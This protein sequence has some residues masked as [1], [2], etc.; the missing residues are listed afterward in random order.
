[1]SIAWH[2]PDLEHEYDRV[3]VHGV[4]LTQFPPEVALR[5]Y[6]KQEWIDWLSYE[7]NPTHWESKDGKLVT[8]SRLIRTFQGVPGDR[9]FHAARKYLTLPNGQVKNFLVACRTFW[10]GKSKVKVLVKGSRSVMHGG[11][12]HFYYAAH[13]LFVCKDIEIHFVDPNEK[14]DEFSYKTESQSVKLVWSSA[15]YHG[16]GEGFDVLIDDAWEPVSGV[17]P[18]QPCSEYYSLKG[19]QEES[20]A[21]YIPFLH[22]RETRFFSHTPVDSKTPCG[23]CVCREISL[24]AS[25]FD[26]YEFLRHACT[27]LD[28]N[29]GCLRTSFDHDLKAKGDLLRALMT[30]TTVSI[31]KPVEVRAVMSLV[32]CTR[33]DFLEGNLVQVSE[34]APRDHER[35]LHNEPFVVTR[36]TCREVYPWL[37]GKEVIFCGVNPSVLGTTRTVTLTQGH[38]GGAMHHIAFCANIQSAMM[39]SAATMY[40]PGKV[41]DILRHLP[42]WR[43]TGRSVKGFREVVFNEQ[44]APVTQVVRKFKDVLDLKITRSLHPLVEDIGDIRSDAYYRHKGKIYRPIK[45]FPWV[46]D[47]TDGMPLRTFRGYGK[48]QTPSSVKSSIEWS[49]AV[50]RKGEYVISAV[51]G[52]D[53]NPSNLIWRNSM[54]EFGFLSPTMFDGAMV[55]R[56]APGYL[57]LVFREYP[58]F[59]DSS[60]E[61]EF[62]KLH[63]SGMRSEKDVVRLSLFK[64]ISTILARSKGREFLSLVAKQLSESDRR[65]WDYV[66]STR[67]FVVTGPCSD[68]KCMI[69]FPNGHYATVT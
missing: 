30:K 51:E 62:Y 2:K 15:L 26:H 38:T 8:A 1:M 68:K 24:V 16:N 3:V 63:E 61:E 53:L 11:S 43:M 59:W 32:E 10:G 69:S 20:D 60:L 5:L 25:S 35:F 65:M 52:V 66:E 19:Q 67:Y 14:N 21:R 39:T 45:L 28:H 40:V 17:I 55:K 46:T 54:G 37:E 58:A 34:S 48:P 33:M 49:Y 18:M 23:C 36:E 64:Q 4:E 13:L 31:Q 57:K 6:G 50:I 56:C 7:M 29:T 9:W 41:E 12:W 27:V 22:P 47:E 42:N 44:L